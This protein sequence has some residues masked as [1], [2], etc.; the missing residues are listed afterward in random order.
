MTE[1]CILVLTSCGSQDTADVLTGALVDSGLAASVSQIPGVQTT[2]RYLGAIQTDV[3]VLLLIYTTQDKYA[4]VEAC[5]TRLHTYEVPDIFVVRIEGGAPS[6]LDW[7]RQS[8][9]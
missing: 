3:E 8:T 4:E 2:F 1:T 6:A 7:L 9:H 5:I